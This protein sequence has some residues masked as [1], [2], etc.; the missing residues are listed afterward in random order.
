MEKIIQM[1]EIMKQAVSQIG[2]LHRVL[3]V[4]YLPAFVCI[5]AL[6]AASLAA[7][8]PLATLF[9][10]PAVL[11]SFHPFVGLIS[12]MG[13]LLWCAAGTL[14]LFGAA[15]LWK[16]KFKNNVMVFLFWSA[17]LTSFLML[18]D[19][20]LLHEEVLP[21]YFGIPE[22]LVFA[23]YVALAALYLWRF[24]RQILSTD[25]ALMIIA[26]G[27]FAG[28]VFI[29]VLPTPPTDISFA[30]EDTLKFFGIIAWFGY[31]ARTSF[32]EVTNQ[33]HL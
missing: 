18:D 7:Q 30:I 32:Q 19:L 33:P 29:D 31:F 27:F 24:R 25:Y 13:I 1:K 28:S 20:L 6:V 22:H 21:G 3:L 2:Q 17:L 26:L 15:A 12:N 9:R 8:K 23:L 14:A 11:M 5:A 10:D 16:S 4:M